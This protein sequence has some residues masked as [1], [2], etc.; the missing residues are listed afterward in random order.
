MSGSVKGLAERSTDSVP[1][2]LTNPLNI[3]NGN[4]SKTDQ[5]STSTDDE[6][7]NSF[8]DFP[9]AFLV[10]D[11]DLHHDRDKH[12]HR[13]SSDFDVFGI[14]HSD[15]FADDEFYH[16]DQFRDDIL[17]DDGLA[18]AQKSFSSTTSWKIFGEDD[19]DDLDQE[20]RVGT[21]LQQL[22]KAPNRLKSTASNAQTLDSLLG[23][24]IRLRGYRSEILQ[25]K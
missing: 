24:L 11:Q 3:E 12:H 15:E 5:G 1:S 13:L 22:D 16:E 19:G 10:V 8:V 6:F 9:P 2:L 25:N 20:D 4:G 21:F 23:D 14:Q 18:F 17:G 7:T